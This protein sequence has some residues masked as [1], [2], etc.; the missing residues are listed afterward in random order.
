MHAC[1]HIYVGIDIDI[2]I[3]HTY[4][5]NIHIDKDILKRLGFVRLVIHIYI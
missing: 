1:R 2:D 5:I 4:E 3:Q